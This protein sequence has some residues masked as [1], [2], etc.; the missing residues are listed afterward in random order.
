MPTIEYCVY[1]IR[2]D[3]KVLDEP[4]FRKANPH[5]DPRKPC[6]Y[7]GS[8]GLAPEVRFEQHRTGV[9]ANGYVREFGIALMKSVMDRR[10]P[11]RTKLAAVRKEAAMA[12]RLRR[13]GYAVWPSDEAFLREIEKLE[14]KRLAKL[15]E[16]AERRRANKRRQAA[17]S[18]AAPGR[19][20]AP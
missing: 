14:A 2:L 9:N 7:V 4:R 5:H 15:A 11:A 16:R 18:K 12:R 20:G 1:V 10:E 3:P 8:T 19:T 17:G 6:V 13:A